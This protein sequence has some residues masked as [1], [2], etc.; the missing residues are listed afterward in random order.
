MKFTLKV[1][2]FF[3]SSI[4]LYGQSENTAIQP[5]NPRIGVYIGESAGFSFINT[6]NEKNSYEF[7][8]GLSD[9]LVEVDKSNK[10]VNYKYYDYNN[11]F[12]TSL[13]WV[14]H[15]GVILQP[16]LAYNVKLGLCAT[17]IPNA[18]YQIKN[19]DPMIIDEQLIFVIDDPV[20]KTDVDYGVNYLI[21][22]EYLKS[23]K[24]NLFF[25]V[26][27][28]TELS[29]KNLNTYPLFRIGLMYNFRFKD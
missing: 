21:S 22:M 18:E 10:Y 27:A 25:D 29:T 28:F 2:A 23:K 19:D 13:N 4:A 26:G 15:G 5:K 9:V 17:V 1:I 14:Y 11:S 20:K 12:Y 3:M 7:T 16:K 24:L 6:I 8:L